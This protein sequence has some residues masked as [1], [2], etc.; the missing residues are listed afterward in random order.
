ML[1][2]RLNG[3][4]IFFLINGY[5]H[6]DAFLRDEEILSQDIVKFQTQSNKHFQNRI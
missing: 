1:E 2:R 3:E 6:Y 4:P 5:S